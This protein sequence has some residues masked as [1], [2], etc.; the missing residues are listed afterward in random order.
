MADLTLWKN[1]QLRQLKADLNRM[2]R[3]FWADFGGAVFDDVQGEL[4]VTDIQETA[5]RMII[6]VELPGMDFEKLEV[7]VSPE[8]LMISGWREEL[9]AG[10]GG[11]IERGSKFSSRIKLPCLVDPE[12]VEARCDNHNLRIIL[13]KCRATA[14]KK[15]VVRR[16]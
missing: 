14:F 10:A 3:D 12:Q 9:L 13:P 8:L 6:S 1:E 11:S 5:E 15:I 4:V 16:S 7:A 2:V